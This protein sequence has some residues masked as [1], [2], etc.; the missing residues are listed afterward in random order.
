MHDEVINKIRFYLNEYSWNS[1]YFK[2]T[3]THYFYSNTKLNFFFGFDLTN[4]AD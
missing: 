4:H 2:I 3:Q 1:N